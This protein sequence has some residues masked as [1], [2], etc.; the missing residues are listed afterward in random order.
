MP[1]IHCIRTFFL[2][3]VVI[4]IVL[5]ALTKAQVVEFEMEFDILNGTAT[6]IPDT[7]YQDEEEKSDQEFGYYDDSDDDLPSFKP[8]GG[9]SWDYWY[10]VIIKSVLI[11]FSSYKAILHFEAKGEFNSQQQLMIGA[12]ISYLAHRTNNKNEEDYI[13]LTTYEQAHLT[14]A[15]GSTELITA[16]FMP[17]QFGKYHHSTPTVEPSDHQSTE[18]GSTQLVSS[19]IVVMPSSITNSC[20]E[21][22]PDPE[23]VEHDQSLQCPHP[24][25]NNKPCIQKDITRYINIGAEDY[26]LKIE[27]QSIYLYE[28]D[29]QAIQQALQGSNTKLS[30]EIHAVFEGKEIIIIQPA[31][32]NTTQL[33]QT[34]V[35]IETIETNTMQGAEA[36]V[37]VIDSD[38]ETSDMAEP[39]SPTQNTLLDSDL[40]VSHSPQNTRKKRSFQCLYCQ[41]AFSRSQNLKAHIRI[42]TGEKPYK[43]QHCQKAFTRKHHLKDHIRIHTGEKPYKC[44]YCQNAFTQLQTLKLHIRRHTGEKPIKCRYCDTYFRE[45]Q[46]RRNHELLHFE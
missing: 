24:L 43:C 15:E 13:D 5:P 36:D 10:I 7:S 16:K 22:A 40:T 23:E 37:I 32:T 9:D 11:G 44:P 8:H 30:S 38:S 29:N 2:L 41:K 20:D 34:M 33:N 12:A 31:S 26:P 21:G 3:F 39:E 27:G 6:I 35:Q 46:S 45:Y 17:V 18:A 42:H 28:A 4:F 19:N 25:C 14:D 1:L